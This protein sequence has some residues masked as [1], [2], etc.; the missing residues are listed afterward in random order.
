MGGLLLDISCVW[1]KSGFKDGGPKFWSSQVGPLSGL[2]GVMSVCFHHPGHRVSG[3]AHTM[4]AMEVQLS[5][6][7][8]NLPVSL[9]TT[10]LKALYLAVTW[11][12]SFMV[13]LL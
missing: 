9:Y 10:T 2:P 3:R 5:T 11:L 8:V 4:D 6:G 12:F 7:R 13:I 1:G